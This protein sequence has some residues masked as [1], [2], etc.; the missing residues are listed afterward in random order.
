MCHTYKYI[1]MHC[2]DEIMNYAIFFFGLNRNSNQKNTGANMVRHRRRNVMSSNN[3]RVHRE[4]HAQ[5][6]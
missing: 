5:R 1:S 4:K 2:D 3:L 6:E